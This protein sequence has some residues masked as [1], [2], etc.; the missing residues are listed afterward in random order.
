MTPT[1]SV[2]AIQSTSWG[3][4]STTVQATNWGV[5]QPTTWGTAT[6]TNTSGFVQNSPN[7]SIVTTSFP[8]TITTTTTSSSLNNNGVQ[9]SVS[10]QA[11]TCKA[12]YKLS[13]NNTCVS[14][15]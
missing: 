4:P 5:A 9:V 13:P 12:P 14:F 8:S 3:T 2:G 6:T 1:T 10:I 15:C 7:N 11:S